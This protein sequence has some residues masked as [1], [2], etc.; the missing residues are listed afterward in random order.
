[1]GLLKTYIWSKISNN[2]SFHKTLSLDYYLDCKCDKI[3][4]QSASWWN[5][6]GLTAV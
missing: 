3:D 4:L 6:N 2:H 1:M 5:V